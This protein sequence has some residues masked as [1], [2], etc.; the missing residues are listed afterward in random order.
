MPASCKIPHGDA[1]TEFQDTYG[2][3][4]P[5]RPLKCTDTDGSEIDDGSTQTNYPVGATCTKECPQYYKHP[6]DS[7]GIDGAVTSTCKCS[8]D[9]NGK[10]SCNFDPINL[11][12]CLPA[13]C[14]TNAQELYAFGLEEEA[15]AIWFRAPYRLNCEKVVPDG[16]MHAGKA[17][18]GSS[19]EVSCAPGWKM[20]DRSMTSFKLYCGIQMYKFGWTKLGPYPRCVQACEDPLPPKNLKEA[21]IPLDGIIW[22][23][24]DSNY[25]GSVCQKACAEGYV[26][27]GSKTI[28]ACQCKGPHC[29]G[30]PMWRGAASNCAKELKRDNDGKIMRNDKETY[31]EE[32]RESLDAFIGDI[33]G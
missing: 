3:T 18:Y 26:M 8:K 7:M 15:K 28:N 6:L 29:D 11:F 2:W 21:T 16:H 25:V 33:F 22:S 32:V 19:C 27:K 23:C 1:P 9:H 10:T 20:E 24:N 31:H 5:P 14:S 13:V 17:E 4:W 12:T 30:G